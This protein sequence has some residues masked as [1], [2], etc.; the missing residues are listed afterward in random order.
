MPTKRDKTTR[1]LRAILSADV[2]GYS[3]LM[4]DDEAF[5]I[6]TLKEYRNIMSKFIEQHAGRIV[7]SPGDNILAEFASAVDAVQCA[8]EIQKQ[9]KKENDRLVEDKKLEFRIGVNIGDVVKDGDRIYGS[10]V[11]IAARIEGLADP[12]GVC[13]SRNAYN[14]IKDKLELGYEYLG[15]NKVKNINDPVRVYKVLMAPDDAG[16]PIG[17]SRKPSKIKWIGA[18]AA[19]IVVIFF[20]VWQLYYKK[21]LEVKKEVVNQQAPV[22]TEKPSIAI[23]PFENM[24][25]D[26]E[27]EY[28]SD[29]MTDD[30]I[31]DLSKING[32]M[33][34]SRNSAFTYKG[35]KINIPEV[36]E[37][38][39]VRYVLEGSV[40][41]AG[42]Q[43]RINAQLIDAKTDHHIW[44]DR[45]DDTMK[46]I[47][48]LQDRV[49]EKIVSALALKLSPNETN[50]LA[51]KGTDN[52]EAHDLYLKGKAHLRRWTRD[53]LMKAI[54]Y[55]KQALEMDPNYSQAYV[56]LAPAF[57][58]SVIGS[59]N[60]KKLVAWP[61]LNR[62][63]Y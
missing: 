30:I 44:A 55:F 54:D 26:P 41:K 47:F 10:G 5:T 63:R 17:K 20:V 22:S 7:D 8:V 46:N 48:S 3:L 59:L 29:G 13:I 43:V 39:G 25:N 32:L 12:G 37:R 33:V 57:F 35:K 61:N 40:R 49:T 42:D 34:I 36:A 19:A 18:A 62:P 14:Q 28:F 23:L 4:A 60:R 21:S 50:K 58:D 52:I 11:N 31:T 24:S 53:D 45:F 1:K 56:G 15:E 27:Q 51:S 2:K 16:R 6:Q 38:L 9:L